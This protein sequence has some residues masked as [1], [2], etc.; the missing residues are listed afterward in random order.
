[1]SNVIE[2]PARRTAQL[3]LTIRA[4]HRELAALAD[5]RRT[6]EVLLGGDYWRQ[7]S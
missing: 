4:L 2:K 1:M 3:K 6:T 5:I 7:A